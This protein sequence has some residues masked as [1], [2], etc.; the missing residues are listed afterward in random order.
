[1]A[2]KKQAPDRLPIAGGLACIEG[3]VFVR[4]LTAGDARKHREGFQDGE[5][6]LVNVQTYIDALAELV[7]VDED[8][9]RVFEDGEVAKLFDPWQREVQKA[10]QAVY[11]PSDPEKNLPAGTTSPAP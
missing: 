8:G 7:V 11:Y 9:A 2:K 3:P 10:V 6:E 5:G 4:C 1:M